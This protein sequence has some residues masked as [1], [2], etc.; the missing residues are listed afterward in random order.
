MSCP[1]LIGLD[2]FGIFFAEIFECKVRKFRLLKVLCTARSRFFVMPA[3]YNKISTVSRIHAFFYPNRFRGVCLLGMS[4]KIRA[5]GLREYSA[6]CW[7]NLQNGGMTAM[8]VR[9]NEALNNRRMHCYKTAKI[10][11]G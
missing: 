1:L 6:I 11:N 8:G 4:V 2:Q 9:R 7:G 3:I 5:E 10:I